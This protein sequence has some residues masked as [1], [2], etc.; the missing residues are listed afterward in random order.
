[1]KRIVTLAGMVAAAAVMAVPALAVNDTPGQK[2]TSSTTLDAC[3]YF[4][5]SQTANKTT[6]S[7]ATYTEKGTWTGVSNNYVNTPVASSGT[8]TGSYS[9]TVTTN[10][11]GSI[12]GTES[13]KSDAGQIDQIFAYNGTWTVSVTATGDLSFLTSDTN[14][15]CYTGAFPR[16]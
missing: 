14:G 16:P 15:D 1:M 12:S 2:L 13:F 4:V 3:G 10:P 8:V 7:G 11:D 6:T 9:E 5:G